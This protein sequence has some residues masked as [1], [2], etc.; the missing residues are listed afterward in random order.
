MSELFSNHSISEHSEHHNIAKEIAM[1]GNAI[2]FQGNQECKCIEIIKNEDSNCLITNFFIG[3]D[4]LVENRLA[5][6]VSPKINEGLGEV[7]YVKMLF[8][9]LRHFEVSKFTDDLYEIKFDKPEIEIDQ[10]D[11]L[12]TPLLIAIYL[13]VVASIV[14][15]GLKSNYY[16]VI[17]NLTG[18]IRGK[19]L[20]SE[21][22]KSNIFKNR[23]TSTLCRFEEFGI[24]NMEN[25]VLKMALR[26]SQR[27]LSRL[28]QQYK[29]LE[30]L[31]SFCLPFFESV[32]D[33]KYVRAL[34]HA[35][36]NVFFKEYDEGLRLATIILRRFGYNISEVSSKSQKIKVP[37]FW[38]N[39]PKLFELYVLAF[40]KDKYRNEISY[41]FQGTYGQPDFLLDSSEGKMVLD[42]KYKLKYQD[43]AYWADDIRQLSGYARDERVLEKLGFEAYDH[44]V[45]CIIIYPDQ[46]ALERLDDDFLSNPI[47]GF[48]KFYKTAVRL[49]TISSRN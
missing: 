43:A 10:K 38:I 25:R 11:D 39:M 5:I 2:F 49:P 24:D 3:I 21:T 27:Y 4:W 8:S 6:Y 28:P 31:M 32:S 35:K 16:D 1:P 12:L 37:P 48:R 15:K 45:D 7:D 46:S 22:L 33:M 47:T 13:K 40:L 42:A 41:Q 14:R 44:I 20:V 26:F 34:N 36:Q 29:Q 18:R 30:H 19:I 23:P 17:S 9:A